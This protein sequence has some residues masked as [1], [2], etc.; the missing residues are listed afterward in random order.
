MKLPCSLWRPSIQLWSQ[1]SALQATW[2]DRHATEGLP[3][4]PRTYAFPTVHNNNLANAIIHGWEYHKR[5]LLQS[6]EISCGVMSYN[7][8]DILLVV[9]YVESGNNTMTVTRTF[10]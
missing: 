1:L 9:I 2:C 8:C 6:P 5:H 7:K 4:G 3:V 10:S